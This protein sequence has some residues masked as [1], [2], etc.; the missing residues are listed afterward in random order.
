MCTTTPTTEEQYCITTTEEQS[1]SRE[2]SLNL[3]FVHAGGQLQTGI[4]PRSLVLV[5]DHKPCAG[6]RSQLASKI[7]LK[8]YWSKDSLT[9]DARADF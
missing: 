4:S 7:Q 3:L 8:K 5:D 2:I 1:T 6:A 9:L